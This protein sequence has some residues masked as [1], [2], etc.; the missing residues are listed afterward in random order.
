MSSTYTA[1]D[2]SVPDGSSQNGAAVLGAVTANQ[3][4]LWT[5]IAMGVLPGWSLACSGGTAAEPGQF[6]FSNGGTQR[7]KGVV[8]WTS[9]N[10]TQIVWTVSQ[11]S[12]STYSSTV[13]TETHTFDGSGNLT[14]ASGA[15]G[16]LVFFSMLL[17]KLKALTTRVAATEAAIAAL[18][19]MSLQDSTAVAITGGT[20]KGLVLGGTGSGEAKLATVLGLREKVVD[21]GTGTPTNTFTVDF[22][23]GEIFLCQVGAN[24][25]IA[26]TN[27]P[28]NGFAQKVVLVITGALGFTCTLPSGADW[29]GAGAPTFTAGPDLVTY[30]RTGH[31]SAP[32]K[33]FMVSSYGA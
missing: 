20:A 21:L 27:A 31:A 8:T 15:S 17:G 29:G 6:L 19:D 14:A 2:P 26:E 18:G 10:I 32:V 22:N 23:A 33:R 11:D 12:G 16:V 30:F 25:T 28:A 13:A 5:A 4:A 7:I 24:F 9:G 1:F 3:Y